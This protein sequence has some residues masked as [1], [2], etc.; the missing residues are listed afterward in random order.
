MF[1][2]SS[3]TVFPVAGGSFTGRRYTGNGLSFTTASFATGNDHDHNTDHEH[4]AEPGQ[5]EQHGHG[6]RTDGP[7]PGLGGFPFPFAPPPPYSGGPENNTGLFGIP[8]IL[9]DLFSSARDNR[10]QTQPPPPQ[11][12]NADEN[13]QDAATGEEP[14][15]PRDTEQPQ[16]RV[17]RIMTLEQ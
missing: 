13:T 2:I 12:Q 9:Q 11:Q 10:S 5:H 16:A 7:P 14:L 4:N 3:P 6:Q 8:N 17:P 15:H 1:T